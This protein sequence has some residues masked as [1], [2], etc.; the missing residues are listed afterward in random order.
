MDPI[1]REN[2]AV[3]K[4]VSRTIKALIDD[5]PAENLADVQDFNDGYGSLLI[6]WDSFH[7]RYNDWRRTA[8]RVRP[9]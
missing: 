9:D 7:Q 2:E 8:G 6:E 1:I 5:S 3:L 4:E